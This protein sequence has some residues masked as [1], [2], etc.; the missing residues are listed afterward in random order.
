VHL[1]S[2]IIGVKLFGVLLLV[3][4][5][6]CAQTDR[7]GLDEGFD[8]PVKKTVVDLGP[9]PYYRPT[10]HVRKKLTCYYY[11]S[12][13]VKQYDEGQKGAEWLSIV[14]LAHA[15]CTQTQSEGENVLTS[16][17]WSGYF[18]GAKDRYAVFVA[19][20]G[21]DGGLP[22]AV[23][24]VKTGRSLF[25]DASLLEYYQKT[26]HIKNAFRITNRADQIP[27]LTYFRVVRAGCDLKTEQADC[28]NK[29]RAQFGITQT[30]MP[31]C[32]R[33]E[34][35]EGSSESAIVYPVS[36]LLTDSPQIKAVDGPVFCWPTD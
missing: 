2:Y 36:V 26:L 10:E 5:F 22:F 13:A 11:S 29:V 7:A 16:R 31:V 8:K 19:P 25:E 21:D 1:R 33:Y 27:R 9:S 12:F 3:V 32:S 18:W 17:E 24:D 34:Q 28:W 35:A 30:D 14:P 6:L 23:F 4:G 20:D 15:G